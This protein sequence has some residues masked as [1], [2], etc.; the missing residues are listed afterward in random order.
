[1]QVMLRWGSQQM[2][3]IVTFPNVTW[4]NDEYLGQ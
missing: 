3:R 2:E 4:T 1:V